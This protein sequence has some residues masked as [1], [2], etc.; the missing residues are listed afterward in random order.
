MAH[1][2]HHRRT[3]RKFGFA[4]RTRP[5]AAPGSVVVNPES[6]A[7]LVQVM[8]FGPA[9]C[10]ELRINKIDEIR[11]LLNEWPVVWIDVEGLG[12]ADLI[13]RL[14]ELLNLHH[15]ALEDVVNVHQRA[16][17]EVYGDHL[18]IV[19]RMVAQSEPFETEQLSM[20]L[21]E[22]F[23]LTLQEERP[24]DPFDPVRERLRRN[25]GRLSTSSPGQ[26]A[27][28]LLDA[29]VDAYFPLLERCGER[30]DAIETDLLSHA[31]ESAITS[32]HSIKSELLGMRRAIWPLREAVNC[33]LRDHSEFFA[34]DT[35]PYLRDL[36]DHTFQILDLIDTGRELASDLM[37]VYLSTVS[38]RMNEVMRVLTIIATVFMPLTFVAGIYGMNFNTQASPWNMPELNW[39]LG[40]P[41]S[42]L[43]MFGVTGAMMYFFYRK[44]W[45][46]SLSPKPQMPVASRPKSGGQAG[47]GG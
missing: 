47:D 22:R 36:H 46:R 32:I 10:R 37:D 45:L 18:F 43:L 42:L 41:F 1:R 30:L 25:H 15:L 29:V 6:Q 33:L 13:L 40:Y 44:G 14:G 19:A 23:V 2:S 7:P 20:F 34:A 17:V 27:H 16:K 9:G 28:A 38:N 21:G 35:H 3:R 26:F 24:G 31:W 12:D 11:P 4:R 5:G 39:Y 8:A